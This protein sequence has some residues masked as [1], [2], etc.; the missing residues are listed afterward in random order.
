MP[1]GGISQLKVKKK[2][3]ILLENDDLD[4]ETVQVWPHLN[5]LRPR[6]SRQ[7][8]A[9]CRLLRADPD[10]RRI[11]N[12]ESSSQKARPFYDEAICKLKKNRIFV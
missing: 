11:G 12:A 7:S 5:P 9:M 6:L 3:S 2:T 4:D 8:S 1:F 10:L